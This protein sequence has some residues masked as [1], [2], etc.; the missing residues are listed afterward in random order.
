MLNLP[1]VQPATTPFVFQNV[2]AVIVNQGVEFGFDYDI[3][4]ADDFTWNANLNIAFNDNEFTD[5]D[6]PDLQ[7]GTLFG[8]GLTDATSQILTEGKSLFTYNLRNV[9][10]NLN[11][12]SEPTVQDKSGLPDITAGFSTGASYKNWDASLY[13]S[14]QFG[15]YVYNNTANALFSGPQLGSRNNLKDIVDGGVILSS[16]NPSTIF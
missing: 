6:G 5:Y 9:D 16:T 1:A 11:V 3:V 8:Q 7:A 14:G 10:E 12:D 2:D 15:H 13:F 4:R